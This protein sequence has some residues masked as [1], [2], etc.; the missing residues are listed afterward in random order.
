MGAVELKDKLIQIINSSSDEN[1]LKVLFDFAK[2]TNTS[3]DAIVAYT[4]NGTPLTREQYIANN[5]EAVAS[6][7][8]GDFK[9]TAQLREKFGV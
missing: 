1:Y 6:F 9:T 3:D 5:E 2:H 4:I 8:R 7:K